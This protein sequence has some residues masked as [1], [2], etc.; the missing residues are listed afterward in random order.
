MEKVEIYQFNGYEATIIIPEK[1][2]GKWIWKI[3][4]WLDG[5]RI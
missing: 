2:N 5:R 4:A 3:D 1:P